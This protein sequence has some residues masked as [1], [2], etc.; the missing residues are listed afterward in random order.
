MHAELPLVAP[1]LI[2]LE[3]HGRQEDQERESRADQEDDLRH[4]HTMGPRPNRR[5]GPMVREGEDLRRGRANNSP[6]DRVGHRGIG[7][8]GS[9][10]LGD[11]DLRSGEA[12]VH[13][14]LQ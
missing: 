10:G 11:A 8:I 6:G 12:A 2:E 9:A 14:Q 13:R 1:L 3:D 7:L 5:H 4:R